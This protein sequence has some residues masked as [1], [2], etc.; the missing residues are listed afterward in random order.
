M[1]RLAAVL[2]GRRSDKSDTGTSSSRADRSE[3]SAVTDTSQVSAA[4]TTKTAKSRS[5]FFRSMSRGALSG[6]DLKGRKRSMP[7]VSTIPD[8][9]ASSASSSS[10]GPYTPSDDYESLSPALPGHRRKSWLSQV[11]EAALP[12]P[13]PVPD[14]PTT[15]GYLP[16]PFRRKSDQ[17]SQTSS[18]S[19]STDE[20][21][22]ER[23]LSTPL[24][25]PSLLISPK[26]YFRVATTNA[27]QPPY[28][29]P[30]LIHVP[31]GPLFPRSCNPSR[32]LPVNDTLHAHV[33]RKRL[34]ARLDHIPESALAGFAGRKRTPQRLPSLVLDDVAIPKSYKVLPAS[35]GLRRWAERPCFEDRMIVY[36]PAEQTGD[37]FRYERV[38]ASAAVEALG[39]S[40]HVEALAGLLEDAG[41]PPEVALDPPSVTSTPI[42]SMTPS[43][44]SLA[45]APPSPALTASNPSLPASGSKLTSNGAYLVSNVGVRSS[46]SYP[47][48]IQACS[49]STPHREHGCHPKFLHGCLVKVCQCAINSPTDT[50]SRIQLLA[51]ASVSGGVSQACGAI[52]SGR[53]R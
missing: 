21:D 23:S 45:S 37:D 1:R 25:T 24:S 4:T 20:Q 18:E 14:K 40:E 26:E 52:R 50:C 6:P 22:A 10:G 36:L 38:Y 16:R 43:T 51:V 48:R 11:S 32:Q 15:R 12:L 28:S 27:L 2:T 19:E 44:T 39:Y 5:G 3:R 34:L 33:L 7:S 31:R 35:Q 9:V 30:P 53:Q 47:S 41:S 13:P 42:L 8:H 29:P 17:T 49:L 46:C